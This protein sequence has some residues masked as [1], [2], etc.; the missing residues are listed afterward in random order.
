MKNMFCL[1]LNVANNTVFLSCTDLKLCFVGGRSLAE[2]ERE[3]EKG[4]AESW[5]RAVINGGIFHDISFL[6]FFFFSVRCLWWLLF[7]SQGPFPCFLSCA[8]GEKRKRPFAVKC[9]VE[10]VSP[11]SRSLFGPF[12]LLQL[13]AK[14]FH[15][16]LCTRTYFCMHERQRSP[17]TTVLYVLNPHPK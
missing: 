1:C 5:T 14:R 13:A 15:E 11:L 4:Q 8:K 12:S 2:R 3:R 10:E 16:R 7:I 6:F 9:V 17:W